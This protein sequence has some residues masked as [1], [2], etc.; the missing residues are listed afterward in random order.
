MD[1]TRGIVSSGL[2]IR[3]MEA[4]KVRQPLSLLQIKGKK[5][6]DNLIPLIMEELNVKQIEFVDSLNSKFAINQDLALNL[7]ITPELKEE[8][9]VREITR[10]IQG[11]RKDSGCKPENR[12]VVYYSGHNDL[13]SR[14][15]DNIVETIK[16][17]ELINQKRDKAFDVEKDFELDGQHLWLALKIK[18]K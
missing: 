10:S 13:I 15:K 5:L 18:V 2:K 3:S 12:I 7:E 1:K 8:G 11:M 14:N 4:I 16:A 17:D 9:L 6:N